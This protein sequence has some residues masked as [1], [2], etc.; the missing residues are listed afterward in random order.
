MEIELNLILNSTNFEFF[1]KMI[2]IESFKNP[3][4]RSQDRA[5]IFQNNNI[6]I[7]NKMNKK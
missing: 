1:V 4:N 2:G 7:N 5:K 6:N 3:K